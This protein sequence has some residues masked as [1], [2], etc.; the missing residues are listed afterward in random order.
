MF[1]KCYFLNHVYIRY[2]NPRTVNA[3]FFKCFF[4]VQI[5]KFSAFYTKLSEWLAGIVNK[6]DVKNYKAL[7]STGMKKT[8]SRFDI[9]VPGAGS[10]GPLLLENLA[11]LNTSLPPLLS[12]IE[13]F[14]SMFLHNSA[15]IAPFWRWNRISYFMFL[16]VADDWASPTASHIAVMDVNDIYVTMV[17]LVS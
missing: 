13:T 16:A 8:F 5:L 11:S 1:K 17:R 3:I 14:K 7:R 2:T 6:E 9:V 10:G 4:E 12:A 15:K